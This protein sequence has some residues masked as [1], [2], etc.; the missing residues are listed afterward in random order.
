LDNTSEG[1]FAPDSTLN[2][3]VFIPA[4]RPP[5]FANRKVY[6]S[7][8]VHSSL[9]RVSIEAVFHQIGMEAVALV[10][11]ESSS[12]IVTVVAL[13]GDQIGSSSPFNTGVVGF[14]V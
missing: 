2:F 13:V 6:K 7:S 5:K 3:H 10:G 1:F 8:L 11:V 4:T 14:R 9:T 12:L